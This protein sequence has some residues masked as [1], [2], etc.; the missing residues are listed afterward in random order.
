MSSHVSRC[1]GIF[2]VLLLW[3]VDVLDGGKKRGVHHRHVYNGISWFSN[4]EGEGIDATGCIKM[5]YGNERARIPFVGKRGRTPHV[6][7]T[8]R[9]EQR[10]GMA[11][12]SR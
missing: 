10:M 8:N 7:V 9:F 6:F 3:R 11:R 5:N 2:T 1:G 12:H 4:E